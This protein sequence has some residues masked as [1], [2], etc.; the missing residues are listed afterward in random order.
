MFVHHLICDSCLR[1]NFAILSFK[2]LFNVSMSVFRSLEHISGFYLWGPYRGAG[3]GRGGGSYSTCEHTH[4]HT[5]RAE[6]SRFV[7]SANMCNS[8]H[9]LPC[10]FDWAPS[11]GRRAAGG[12]V[13]PAGA[14]RSCSPRP[15]RMVQHNRAYCSPWQHRTHIYNILQ[16]V[17]Q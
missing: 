2:C 9:P 10:S 16:Y 11:G 6:T 3:G 14:A 17:I 15:A 13:G 4:T 1:N 12:G 5:H 8:L 7:C